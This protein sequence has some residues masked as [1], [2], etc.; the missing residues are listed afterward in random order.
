[1]WGTVLVFAL[2]AAADPVRIGVIALLITRPRPLPN[3]FTFWLGGLTSG[4]GHAVVAL[5]LLRAFISPAVRFVISSVTNP[6]VAPIQVVLGV[7]ALLAAAMLAGRSTVRRTAHAPIPGGDPSALVL[8]SKSP[9]FSRL[10]WREK[11]DGGSLGTAYVAGLCSATPPV[12]YWAAIMAI[13]GSGAI[14]A[15]QFSA[16]MMFTI[17]ALTIA[18]I[19]L[20][21]YLVSPA[22]TLSVVQYLH[23]WLRVYRR[24]IV[25]GM[26]AVAGVFLFV[27]GVGQI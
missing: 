2:F 17:V 8:P 23:D 18:E 10:P 9:T 21:S 1:M 13:I 5:L 19:P 16:A 20:L 7:L 4:L 11:F 14:I 25:A 6:I 3:L 22:K 26:L 24:S 15:A 12:E 27:T